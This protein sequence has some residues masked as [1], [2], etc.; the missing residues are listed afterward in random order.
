MLRQTISG[1]GCPNF[2]ICEKICL[3]N[4]WPRSHITGVSRM[5]CN[6]RYYSSMMCW[7]PMRYTR[8]HLARFRARSVVGCWRYLL[9]FPLFSSL[10]AEHGPGEC[11]MSAIY[12]G[13]HGS[14]CGHRVW[15]WCKVSYVIE[16]DA[17]WFPYYILLGGCLIEWSL[18]RWLLITRSLLLHSQEAAMHNGSYMLSFPTTP[19]IYSSL[20][21]LRGQ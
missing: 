2:Q 20:V 19:Y 21:T 12:G 11:R 1:L 18:L 17:W 9:D 7:D 13:L 4:Q 8:L 14:M 10:R 6:A 5:T 3:F 16:S 15:I